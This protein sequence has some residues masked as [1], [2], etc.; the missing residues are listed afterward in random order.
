MEVEIIESF[1]AI[2]HLGSVWDDFMKAQGCEIFLTFDWCRTW[3]R[4]YGQNR[5]L[6]ILICRVDGKHVAILPIFLQAHLFWPITVKGAQLVGTDHT[7]VVVSV[8]IDTRYLDGVLAVLAAKLKSWRVE[9]MIVG[10][11]AGKYKE[12]PSL[13]SSLRSSLSS[14]YAVCVRTCVSQ[15][16]FNVADSWEAQISTLSKQERKRMRRLYK[17]LAKD[18]IEL[19]SEIA[20]EANFRE[21]FDGFVELHQNWWQSLGKAGHF[22]AWPNAQE[23]HRDVA[24]AQLRSGR[25]RLL[26]IMLN[27][28][29]VGYKYAYRFGNMYTGFLD[30]RSGLELPDNIS[31]FRLG[32]GELVKLSMKEKGISLY[33]SM[34]GEYPHKRHLGGYLLPIHRIMAVDTGFWCRLRVL[35]LQAFAASMHILYLKLWRKRLSSL[36]GLGTGNLSRLWLKTEKLVF[37]KD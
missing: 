23:F 37:P 35:M 21:F 7:P 30:A 32:F 15:T 31:F 29:I 4:Y 17:T 6:K 8:P 26:R 5:E 28:K 18:E 27:G 19:H 1:E 12:L 24:R 11:I 13:V 34:R 33:D 3:W 20:T 10:D 9:F 14:S 2:D 25:L 36:I 16:Y 22:K